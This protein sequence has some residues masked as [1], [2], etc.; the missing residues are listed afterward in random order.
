[1]AEIIFWSVPVVLAVL[2]IIVFLHVRERI[3]RPTLTII[4]P[5][6]LFTDWPLARF[7]GPRDQLERL[8]LIIKATAGGNS[9]LDGVSRQWRIGRPPTN[10]QLLTERQIGA[11]AIWRQVSLNSD[12]SLESIAIGPPDQLGEVVSREQAPKLS[13]LA[14]QA[15]QAGENGFLCLALAERRLSKSVEDPPADHR[16]V[17]AVLLEIVI[18]ENWLKKISKNNADDLP[19]KVLT[20]LPINLTLWIV[21]HLGHP[22]GDWLDGHD[23]MKRFNDS[24]EVVQQRLADSSVIGGADLPVRHLAIKIWGEKHTLAF[25]GQDR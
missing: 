18:G 3:P 23:L 19:I 6:S 1:M 5:I 21:G 9:W 13:E 22:L 24:P 8:L 16:L 10:A 7:F 12:S 15:M 4:D 25:L 20:A 11:I 17:G 2:A 14:A